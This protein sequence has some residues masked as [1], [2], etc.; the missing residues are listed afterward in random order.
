MSQTTAAFDAVLKELYIGPIRNQ[1][2][3]KTRLLKFFTKADLESYKWQ[4]RVA[5]VPL[6]K[7]RNVGVKAIAEEGLIPAAGQ[8]GFDKLQIP[9]REWLGRIQLTSQVMKASQSDRG[10]FTRAMQV[11]Q[12]GLVN[13]IARQRNRALA[14]AGRGILAQA[15]GAGGATA[16]LVVDNP[17]G[18]AGSVN[19]TRFLKAGMVIAIHDQA[20]PATIDALATIATVDSAVQ[21]T[22]D[23]TYTWDDD[24]FITLGVSVG[25]VDEGSLDLEPVGILGIVDSTTFLSTIHGL[26]RSLAANS[27]FRST[28]LSAVGVLSP[29]VVQRGIDNAEEVS[30]EVIDC[31]FAH[32]STRREVL[33]MTEGDRRYALRATLQSPDP[34]TRAGIFKED[35]PLNGLP[36]KTDKDFAYGILLGANK[37][38]LAWI[39]LVEGQWADDDGSILLRAANQDVYEG[40]YRIFE[41]FFS[42]MGNAHVRFDGIT[43]TVSSG[44]F[45]D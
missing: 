9:T 8:Q 42:D 32:T 23:T 45:A 7:S 28:I 30:G 27:Y 18:V 1:L 14:Y 25:A 6:H 2:N 17:G 12:D 4:G 35:L 20:A 13:D 22:L 29:D 43:S 11:E 37:S 33:K 44:V 16:T 38:H 24:A 3:K 21:V 5:I 31:F 10:S 36:V 19:G 34:G 41:N 15:N 26:D 39:P 40:R